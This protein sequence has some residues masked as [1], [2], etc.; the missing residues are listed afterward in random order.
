MRKGCAGLVVV[1][2]SFV[3]VA[4]GNPYENF[5]AVIEPGLNVTEVDSVK[6]L[7]PDMTFFTPGWGSHLPEDTFVFTV[8]FPPWPE[9]ISL[10]GTIY[11]FPAVLTI[12]NPELDTWYRFGMSPE[13]PL[14]KFCACPGDP[15]PGIEE[16]ESAIDRLPRLTV[17]PSVV[18]GKMT[19]RLQPVAVG[20]PVVEIHDAVGSVVRSLNCAAGPSGTATATW[21]RRDELGRLVPEGVYFCRYA[22]ADVMAVRKIIVAH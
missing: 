1:L 13:A 19:V 4:V 8:G 16:S 11:S 6:L 18:T 10:R 22:E 14:V 5:G 21:N 20:R 3:A 7:S 15:D 12:A 9:T 17:S 2:F